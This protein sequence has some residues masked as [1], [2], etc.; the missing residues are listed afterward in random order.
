MAAFTEEQIEIHARGILEAIG[1]KLEW[2][3]LFT[4][5]PKIMEI[6]GQVADMTNE[7]KHESA[8]PLANYV[9]D[10]TDTP[11]V[12]DNWTD[13]ILKKGVDALIPVL[14]DASE[15]KFDFKPKA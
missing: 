10:K 3:D 14:F 13:P 15:G 11:W 5:V 6:V 9:I 1:P 2:K 4:L 8:L 12:P 7:E